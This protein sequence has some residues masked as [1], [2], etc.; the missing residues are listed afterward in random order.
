[1]CSYR[2]SKR[3][4]HSRELGVASVCTRLAVAT[5]TS[6]LGKVEAKLVLQPVHRITRAPS[7]NM[8]EVIAGEFAS[9]E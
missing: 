6:D 9:L 3:G 1:M 7:E 2:P 8:N 5:K 4:H